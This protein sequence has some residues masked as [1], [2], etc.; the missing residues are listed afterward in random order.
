MSDLKNKILEEK[1][2]S[3]DTPKSD[4]YS[5]KEIDNYKNYFIGVGMRGETVFIINSDG[6]KGQKNDSFNGK[7]LDISTNIEMELDLDGK[8]ITDYFVILRLKNSDLN[9][10]KS[11]F[12]SL[13]SDILSKFGQDPAFDDLSL[14]LK[15]IY[16]LFSKLTEKAKVEE[17][18]LWGE[19]FL[20]RQSNNKELMIDSW[21]INPKD[22]LDFNSGESKIE[23]KTTPRDERIH[24]FKRSQLNILTQNKGYLCSIM[25]SKIENGISIDKLV[26]IIC[27]DL[28]TDYV[29]KLNGKVA[30]VAGISKFESEFDLRA[31]ENSINFYLA[32]SIPNIGDIPSGMSSV[33]FNINIENIDKM[34]DDGN[35]PDLISTVF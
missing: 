9:F 8:K 33:K 11:Y 31:A 17:I 16:I 30:A 28:T 4:Y 15:S 32:E 7:F 34:E 35:L 5:V 24:K 13:C 20:I 23:V 10:L 3:L 27:Q 22:T 14:H 19:L 12:L 1:L 6:S 2:L 26:E 29:L 18:G 25:T 21:H